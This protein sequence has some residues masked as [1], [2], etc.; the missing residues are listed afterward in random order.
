MKTT[1]PDP[2]Q[3]SVVSNPRNLWKKDKVVSSCKRH[4]S[5]AWHKHNLNIIKTIQNL[6]KRQKLLELKC[7]KLIEV[8][9]KYNTNKIE[10]SL[11]S[12]QKSLFFHGIKTLGC[13]V[14][15]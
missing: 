14:K 1:R 10:G 2:D 4:K 12:W 6:K 13:H 9:T 11:K 5:S 8:R 3:I 15:L 7:M